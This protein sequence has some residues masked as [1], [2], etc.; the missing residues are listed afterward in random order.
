MRR[1]LPSKLLSKSSSITENTK[2]EYLPSVVSLLRIVVL[3]LLAYS[4][5]FR[6]SLFGYALFL[7]AVGT[8]FADGYV[9]RRLGVA[10][11]FGG[12]FDSVVDLIF[13]LGMFGGFFVAGCYPYWFLPL[14]L[15]VYLQF[16]ITSLTCKVTYDP[17]G[18]YYGSLLYGAIGLTLL[19][20]GQPF[21]DT[22][23]TGIVV[24]TVAALF[25]RLV[26]CVRSCNRKNFCS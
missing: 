2:M 8:D 24:V 17:V 19:F 1:K 12:Y 20:S 4:F 21:Y 5:F 25:S 13:I 11:E 26:Y 3:P 9:A 18:K 7:F 14:I 22:I 6:L 10:S 16:I 15:F 23:K